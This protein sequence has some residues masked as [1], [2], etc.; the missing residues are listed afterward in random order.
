MIE[1]RPADLELRISVA[2]RQIE[3]HM[4][5]G[6]R[7]LARLVARMRARL[8]AQRTHETVER[9]ERERGLA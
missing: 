6:E 7:E 1:T 3:W 5:R 4:A 8:I 9:M 2:G